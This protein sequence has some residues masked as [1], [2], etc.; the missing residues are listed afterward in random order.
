MLCR[1]T[2]SRWSE[3]SNSPLDLCGKISE[4]GLVMLWTCGSHESFEP[5]VE[6]RRCGILAQE[7]LG[8]LSPGALEP[9]AEFV[10]TH[11]VLREIQCRLFASRLQIVGRLELLHGILEHA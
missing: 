7:I 3:H 9:A 2:N 1:S 11:Q 6:V 5:H 8:L 10:R 4:Q